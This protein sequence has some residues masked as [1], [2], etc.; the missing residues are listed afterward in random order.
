MINNK[1]WGIPFS[2]RVQ[3]NLLLATNNSQEINQLAAV[4]HVVNGSCQLGGQLVLKSKCDHQLSIKI[5]F[6]SNPKY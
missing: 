5:A 4:R 1:K 6:S 2:I 3:N